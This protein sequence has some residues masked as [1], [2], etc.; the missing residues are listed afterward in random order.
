MKEELTN[1]ILKIAAEQNPSLPRPV[2]IEQGA[3]ARL[4]GRGAALDSLAL[5]R[6]IVEIEAA[7]DD[8]YGVSVILADDRAM[9]QQRSPFLTV[10][11]LAAY[12]EELIKETSE[13][14]KP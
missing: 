13:L 14:P 8:Q 3:E 2:Q 7:V 5:V 12:I 6:F 11:S 1:L 9:S 10:G 4:Y